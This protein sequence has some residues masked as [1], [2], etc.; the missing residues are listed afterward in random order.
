MIKH[1]ILSD[2]TVSFSWV[3]VFPMRFINC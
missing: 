3:V 1:D 2:Q